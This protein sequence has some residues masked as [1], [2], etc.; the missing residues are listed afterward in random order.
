MLLRN[1]VTD[2]VL[3]VDAPREICFRSVLGDFF[4]LRQLIVLIAFR[5]FLR[6]LLRCSLGFPV[7]NRVC[8]GLLEDAFDLGVYFLVELGSS[9]LVCFSFFPGWP[10]RLCFPN[11]LRCNEFGRDFLERFSFQFSFKRRSSPYTP[12]ELFECVTL[13]TGE[14]VPTPDFFDLRQ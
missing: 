6:R 12:S 2:V 7:C 14:P 13:F 11:L 10:I 4:V 1:V 9:L 3:K 8:V 5:S